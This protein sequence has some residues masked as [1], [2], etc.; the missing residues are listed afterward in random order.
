MPWNEME[1]GEA[2]K[3][4]IKKRKK[5]DNLFENENR[6]RVIWRIQVSIQYS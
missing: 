4:G 1:T 2:Q 6:G 5:R 3:L